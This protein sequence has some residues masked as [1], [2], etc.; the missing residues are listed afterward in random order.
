M[1][2][3]PSYYRGRSGEDIFYS[4]YEAL[5]IGR[6][7]RFFGREILDVG[8]GDSFHLDI[9]TKEHGRIGYAMDP[10][11]RA[12]EALARKGYPVYSDL[13]SIDRQFDTVFF[14]HVI[15]HVS[16]GSIYDFFNQID[17]LIRPGGNCFL[18]SPVSSAFW[19]TPDHYRI[20]DKPAIR[21]LFRDQGWIEETAVY[22][23]T[24]N[25]M[26]RI[27]RL[28][29]LREP[30]FRSNFLLKCYFYLSNFSK[31]DLIM[32]ARKSESSGV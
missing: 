19:D 12:R 27:L 2:M 11:P 6:F 30:V 13:E 3:N 8:A 24:Q 20:Y 9:L 18:I 29:G 4:R 5:R 17:R 1:E 23:G 14:A 7:I 15:E 16:P 28:S 25:V 21:V 32:T 22:Q 10:N 31:R 26:G